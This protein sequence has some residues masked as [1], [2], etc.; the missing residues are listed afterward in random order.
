[1]AFAKICTRCAKTCTACEQRCT[2]SAKTCAPVS[3]RSPTS[4]IVTSV[5]R[6]PDFAISRRGSRVSKSR[7]LLDRVFERLEEAALEARAL[8]QHLLDRGE[9]ERAEGDAHIPGGVYLRFT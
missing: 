4:S 2:V 6:Q 5:S 1:M 3:R 8:A 7:V 9:I